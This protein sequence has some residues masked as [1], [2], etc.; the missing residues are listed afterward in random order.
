MIY[1]HKDKIKKI[2]INH[3]LNFKRKFIIN[4]RKF[5]KEITFITHDYYVIYNVPQL[6]PQCVFKKIILN[7]NNFT[8]NSFDKIITQ[9]IGNL[10]VLQYFF[11]NSK[12]V[13][14]SE[15][16]D[17]R[18]SLNIYQTNNN[19]IIIGII[20]YINDIKGEKI[21][22]ELYNF[23]DTNKLNM[24]IVVFGFIN[25]QKITS[26]MYKSISHLNTLLIQYKPNILIETS[27][28]METY[29]YTLTLSMLTKLPI[30][31]LYKIYKF[32]INNRLSKY[33]KSY[34][35]NNIDE[36]VY[37]INKYKQDYFYTIE[38]IIYYNSFWDDYFMDNN[39]E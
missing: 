19:K 25:N 7:R 30:L 15:L 16:P 8:L 35:F 6:N 27:I 1:K 17:Y 26:N 11:N 22:N 3:T 28:T 36:C 23:I 24:E 20:G 2:F 37:L 39:I 33:E 31:S 21:V 34:F 14:V 10:N 13:V 4:L 12:N 18:K 32:V 29:S 38:P 5:N 9:N